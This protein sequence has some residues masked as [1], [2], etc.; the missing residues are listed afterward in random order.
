MKLT[1]IFEKNRPSLSFEVFPPKT[2][3]GFD[4][5]KEATEKIAALS[6]SYMSVTYGAGG[7]TKGYTVKIAE[8]I[9]KKYNVPTLSHLTCVSVTKELLRE[10]ADELK[11]AGIENILA[12]RGDLPKDMNEVK[13]DYK[14]ASEIIAD[15]KS[16]GDFCV[17]GACY[18]EGHVESKN[19]TEDIM[20]LKIKTDAGCDFLTTQMFFDNNI[21]YNFLYRIR[22]AGITVPVVAGIM[23]VTNGRQISRIC[24]L[25]GTY[26]PRRFKTIVDKFGE[27]TEAMTKAGIA[28]ATEQIIDLIANGV[29]H[30]HVYSMNKPEV[31]SGIKENLK[32]II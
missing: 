23:P 17:G 20:N 32:G 28:Y 19:L 1:E 3:D 8:N 13:T 25:S 5:V 7:T 14:Y 15:I 29:N 31:A 6:P 4:S 30:I 26:L 18:P 21:M 27:N 12:L 9:Q 11:S 10:T 22:E 24:S 2:S 16:L